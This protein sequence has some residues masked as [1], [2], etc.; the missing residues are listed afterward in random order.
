M[1]FDLGVICIKTKYDD[2]SVEQMKEAVGN[3]LGSDD[4]LFFAVD[5]HEVADL[6]RCLNLGINACIE[7]GCEY[8]HWTHADFTY[9]N[10]SWLVTLKE[11]LIAYPEILKLCAS[12]S[13]D[14]IHPW[15]V[16]QEQSWLMRSADFKK[17]P[18]LWF[19]E[20]FRR[21][22]GSEDYMQHLNILAR[23]F[24]I[25]I[26][27]ETTIFHKGAQARAK[28]NT[29][30]EA[31]HNQGIFATRTAL[32]QLIEVHKPEYF[33]ALLPCAEREAQIAALPG[34]LRELLRVDAAQA[35]SLWE[36]DKKQHISKQMWPLTTFAS[37]KPV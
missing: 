5:G 24:L 35:I 32:G 3:S 17:Y 31:L 13:R 8:I 11:N 18:W 15:R 36:E 26:T 19:D 27:P 4:F 7:T 34:C 9:D 37:S 29:N 10:N 14:E 33:G 6:S 25:A 16:G 21:C 23:G 22:G 2:K 12:N 30:V 28:Y 1:G 20:Q